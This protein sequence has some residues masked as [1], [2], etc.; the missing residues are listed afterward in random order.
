MEAC[1]EK[2][3]LILLVMF[4]VGGD[5]GV[6]GTIQD[7]PTTPTCPDPADIK[8]CN[9]TLT[10]DSKLQ[11]DCSHV[12]SDEQLAAVFSA[13]FPSPNFNSLR[14]WGAESIRTLKSG[15]FGNVTFQEFSINFCIN[16]EEIEEGALSG[17][18]NMTSHLDFGFNNIKVFPF[19]ELKLFYYLGS[20]TVR[21]NNITVFPELSS[22]TLDMFLI[23][24]NPLDAMPVKAFSKSPMLSVIGLYQMDISDVIPG[25]YCHVICL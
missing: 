14:I 17:S 9:C 12:E 20:V 15:V 21:N 8:P 22:P 11:M 4:S 3:L 13:T 23:N 24:G 1:S 25:N 2:F 10:T 19:Q 6:T 16:L 5:A 18:Y 7:P